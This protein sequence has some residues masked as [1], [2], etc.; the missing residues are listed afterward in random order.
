MYIIYSPMQDVAISAVFVLSLFAG[1]TANAA[2]AADNADTHDKQCSDTRFSN[3][4]QE[5]ACDNLGTVRN[6]EGASA[7]SFSI[8]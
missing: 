6:A 2:Y 5:E 4:D 7:V 3:D 8:I 1:A